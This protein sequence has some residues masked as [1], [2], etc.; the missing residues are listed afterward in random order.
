MS[1]LS[2]IAIRERYPKWVCDNCYSPVKLKKQTS[3]IRGDCERCK[4]CN[5]TRSV[6]TSY[7]RVYPDSIDLFFGVIKKF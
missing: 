7:W 4:Y 3:K 1:I 6:R 2:D 5:N